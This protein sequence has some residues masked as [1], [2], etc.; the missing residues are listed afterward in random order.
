MQVSGNT[1]NIDLLSKNID[2]QLAFKGQNEL[3][4]K[5]SEIDKAY[6]VKS[7]LNMIR[8]FYLVID[9]SNTMKLTD[10]KPSRFLLTVNLIKVR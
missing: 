10:Y 5:K 6:S 2:N 8:Y 4:D 7:K 9:L 1:W 3:R